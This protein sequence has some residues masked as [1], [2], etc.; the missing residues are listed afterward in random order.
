MTN[1][2]TTYYKD[3]DF[4]NIKGIDSV[5]KNDFKDL[6]QV[7]KEKEKFTIKV[8]STEFVSN[9]Y[10]LE[11]I[12]KDGYFF[13]Y[14][15]YKEEAPYI[16]NKETFYLKNGIGMKYVLKYEDDKPSFCSVTEINFRKNEIREIGIYNKHIQPSPELSFDEIKKDKDISF[17]DITNVY[18]DN[19]KLKMTMERFNPNTKEKKNYSSYHTGYPDSKINQF[20]NLYRYTFG[21]EIK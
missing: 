5:N 14:E 20:W 8:T 18:E 1:K 11:F 21:K 3:F 19:G 2:E 12:K 17:I 13:K 9:S 7:F 16:N 6:I 10:E 15:E 4:V